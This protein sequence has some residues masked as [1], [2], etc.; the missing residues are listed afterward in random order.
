[1]KKFHLIKVRFDRRTERATQE[2]LN[3]RYKFF[4]ENTLKSLLNQTFQDWMLWLNFQPGMEEMWEE[5]A[6][7]IPDRIGSKIIVS[8]GDTAPRNTSDWSEYHFSKDD[9]NR[10][11][12]HP[13]NY[14]YVTRIDSDDLLSRDAMELVNKLEPKEPNRTEAGIFRRGYMHSTVDGRVGVYY[15]PSSPF[16]TL[17]IPR[18]V[19]IE[20]ER[21]EQLWHRVGEHNMVA[22][23][24]FV[25]ALPDWK[26][27]VLI[28][29]NNFLS[30]FN[31]SKENTPVEGGWNK[32]IWMNQPVVFD[33][34]DFC[35][36]W[37]IETL[38]DMDKLKNVYPNFKA[39][40]FTIPRSTSGVLIQEAKKRDWLE[41]GVHGVTHKPT[42]ELKSLGAQELGSALKRLDYSVYAPVFRPPG[43]YID[44]SH[45]KVL[46]SLGLAV[47]L[48][49]RDAKELGPSCKHGYYICENRTSYEHCHTHNVC[50]NY[51][52]KLLPGLLS[53]WK[54]DQLFS[55]VSEAVLVRRD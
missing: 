34:D 18:D 7:L 29:G 27:C 2:W 22:S 33:V 31:Y 49:S 11:T 10:L 53:K 4:V 45:V 14:V 12:D 25:H 19:F 32:D 39:T 3:G 42:E 44:Y 17:M 50:N 43:W 8:Y 38:K 40:L 28:H 21:Y 20:P 46:N 37:G 35:D 36:E 6:L 52:R 24:C 51:L 30:D 16:H 15:N 23:S 26:F 13:S 48:H 41:L 5:L 1:V 55:F 54:Q 9:W 47:A